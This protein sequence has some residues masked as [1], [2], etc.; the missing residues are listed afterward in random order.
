LVKNNKKYFSLYLINMK[1][2]AKKQ[3]MNEKYF[4][5][6]SPPLLIKSKKE[7]ILQHLDEKKLKKFLTAATAVIKDKDRFP[8]SWE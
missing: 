4:Y 8:L 6:Y 3:P 1:K 2:R 5:F 7:V